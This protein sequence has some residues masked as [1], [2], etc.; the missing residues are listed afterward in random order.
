MLGKKGVS[1]GAP[2]L[3]YQCPLWGL[4]GGEGWDWLFIFLC[5]ALV[6]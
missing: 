2:A 1:R 6:K 5:D 3:Q 4:R